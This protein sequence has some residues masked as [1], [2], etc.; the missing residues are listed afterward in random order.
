MKAIVQD[1]HR[2]IDVLQL[3]DIEKPASN[4]DEVLIDAADGTRRRH[5]TG[6]PDA[7]VVQDRPGRTG[8]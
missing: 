7:S 5:I 4:D 1:H 8:G 3:R 2:D 6:P